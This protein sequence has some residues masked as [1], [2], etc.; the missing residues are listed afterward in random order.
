VPAM[1]PGL[2]IVIEKGRI[3]WYSESAE[4]DLHVAENACGID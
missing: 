3:S 1:R 4:I 2:Q